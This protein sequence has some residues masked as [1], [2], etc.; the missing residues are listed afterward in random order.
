MDE[1]RHLEQ[2]AK[3]LQRQEN[4]DKL[5]TATVNENHNIIICLDEA[6]NN[7]SFRPSEELKRQIKNMFVVLHECTSTGLV[8]ESKIKTLSSTIKA[9]KDLINGEWKIFYA[10]IADGR[11]SKLTTVQSITPDKN[12]T[13][14]VLTKIKN[15]AKLN[16]GDN[17][18]LKLFADGIEEADTIL[19]SLE[20]TDEIL[21]FLDKVS[22][23]CATIMDLTEAVEKWIR[24]E[25]LAEKFLVRFDS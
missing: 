6:R 2:A 9:L 14:F 20:L 3:D 22:E 15:G 7:L 25:K 12:K 17:G 13:R 19:E 8:Q 18:N 24:D 4:A 5:F 16:F 21:S 1:I 11:I 23:G 10:G